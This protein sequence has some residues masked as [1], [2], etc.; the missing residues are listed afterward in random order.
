[1]FVCLNVCFLHSIFQPRDAY[2]GFK[3][4]TPPMDGEFVTGSRFP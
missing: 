3:Q 4:W 1:M 2:F